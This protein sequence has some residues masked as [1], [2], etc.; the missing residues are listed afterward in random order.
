MSDNADQMSNSEELND[1][2]SFTERLARYYSEFLATDFKKGYLPKR[3]F[4]TRDKKGRRTGITLEKFPSFVRVL[5]RSL[6]KPFDANNTVCVKPKAHQAK[7]PN[8]VLA[9]I[10]AEID[11]IEFDE[12]A[13][14]NER[15][16][17]DFIAAINNKDVDVEIEIQ[18]FVHR[19]ERN[20]G[21]VIGAKLI[22][23][24]EPVF[25]KNASNLLD[26]LVAVDDD[27]TEEIVYPIEESLPSALYQITAYEDPSAL[28]DLITS[29][30][31]PEK[32]RNALKEYFDVFS[33]S[34]L[35]TEIR[36]LH[37]LEQLEENKE[38]YLYLG[39]VR[40]KNHV[41]PIFYIPFRIDF[42]DST[43]KLRLE[44]RILVNKKAVDYISR[45]VQE[46]TGLKTASPI[47]NRIIYLTQDDKILEKI[48]DILST[49]LR[50]FQLDGDLSFG[51]HKA[52][53]KNSEIKV[54]N[55]MNMALFD[56]ADESMLTDYEEL[57]EKLG[58]QRTD[59]LVHINSLVTSFL[60]ENPESVMDEVDDEWDSKNI[61]DRL[62]F[63]TPISL[64]EEQ[65]KILTALNHRKG[66]FVTVE[67]PPGTG[68]SHTISAIAFRAIRQGQSVLI[69]SDKKEALDV[70]QNKINHTLEKVRPSD[71]FVNPILR[72][73]RIGNNIG[74]IISNRTIHVLRDHHRKMKKKLDHRREIYKNFTSKIKEDINEKM[75][76][77][78][79]IHLA[80]VFEHERTVNK[81][82][83]QWKDEFDNFIEIFEANEGE[84]VEQIRSI[85]FLVDLR[86]ECLSLDI[87]LINLAKRL[88]SD[89][90]SLAKAMELVNRVLE[91]ENEVSL[92]AVAPRLDHGHLLTIDEKIQQMKTAKWFFGWIYSRSKLKRIRSSI[93]ALTGYISLKSGGDELIHDIQ[94]L[95]SKA[96]KFYSSI[97]KEF[98]NILDII[99]QALLCQREKPY[100]STLIDRLYNIQKLIDNKTIP[101]LGD[102]E[103]IIEIL[104]DEQSGEADFF[105]S[106][107][108]LRKEHFDLEEKFALPR[109]NFFGRKADIE[110]YNSLELAFE[111]DKRAIEFSEKFA[112]DAKT[113]VKIIAEKRKFP[114]DKFERLKQAF[115]CMICSVRDYAEYI[116][117][118]RELFDI[119]IIDEASQV[120][121]AQ[122]FPA[123][124]R[125]K[126]MIVLGD[127]K[128][129]GNVKS[130]NASK[131]IN[132]AYF[133]KV[134][135][136]LIR[137]R[138]TISEAVESRV[139]KL[140]ITNSIMD[141]M[142][143]QRNY[144]VMLRKHFRG[145]PEMISFSSKNFYGNALQAMKIRGKAIEEVLE[146]V[147]LK[148]NGL[149]DKFRN[150]NEQEAQE[151]LCRVIKQLNMGDFRSIAVIT[152]F[153]E[154]Q[155]L[156]SRI[157]SEHER[158][159]EITKKLK[160][161][162][163]TF[164]SCQGEER[165]IIYY[166][167][168]ATPNKDKLWSI[169]PKT[170]ERQEEDE[171]NS[172][173]KLQ[174][175]NVAFSRGKEKL[176]F[177]CSKPITEF[178]AGREALTHYKDEIRNAKAIPRDDAVGSVAERRVLNWI[179][180][181]TVYSKYKPEIQPQYEIG[182]YLATIDSTYKHPM[183]R[184]DFLVRFAI[185]GRQ[186]DIIIEYD[187]FEYHFQN[188]DKIDSGNWYEY[189]NPSD[190]EREH[191][192]ESY[193]CK[194]IR[195][196]KFN[197]GRNPIQTIDDK[198][199]K[200]L[201]EFCE[202]GDNLIKDRLLDPSRD[203]DGVL[204]GTY[205]FCQKCNET[206]CRTK[207][208]RLGI[209]DG[210]AN[211]CNDCVTSGPIK[212]KRKIKRR[213]EDLRL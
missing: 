31:E 53:L 131:E 163:F 106:F 150:T 111:I 212:K 121:I 9:A 133:T 208:H 39:E 57:L 101:F 45:V 199:T 110:N 137:E 95:A 91:I 181:S 103:T 155:I 173:K 194:M 122:A 43:S 190:V 87:S 77:S 172:S 6:E 80:N 126:K 24:L 132:N 48:N 100:C 67:G 203:S 28:N 161:R 44:S 128:Q 21:I 88:G 83:S 142:E 107:V 52:R 168:V 157:F 109:Y 205:R 60:D 56:K 11:K 51:G 82:K 210:L 59:L 115:P 63:D 13:N 202:T 207:F 3:R 16:T 50:A 58:D 19:L 211:Y 196:N 12:L 186:R 64:A 55:S 1:E 41:F 200:V 152:P 14:K 99:P 158:Y 123:I 94:K 138:G 65:R 113:L 149:I 119:I 124:I 2:Y 189:L 171:L 164:D 130:S 159:V 198:I 143:T 96:K 22:N 38:F 46:Q 170:M 102:E 34:D 70:V 117:L 151:I 179:T 120:S 32:I 68:K 89:A 127:R 10:E 79:Q 90:P 17:T 25:Q 105:E 141:F 192:L 97:K 20:V 156:I 72:L 27:I 7:L 174:R 35:A 166:S 160:F 8:V 153:S 145:Y 162:C 187:G 118:E 18:Q 185:D 23:R 140:N 71:D 108:K 148:H 15:S 167:F 86:K 136:S 26:A 195:L 69:L 98:G 201:L 78:Q 4:Q 49:I 5:N 125:A 183:Y 184:V 47:E 93:E 144:Y 209:T 114:R 178:S 129:F 74:K 206:K 191:I 177:V 213:Q 169:L 33:A 188:W 75:T 42:T 66:R 180:Q 154:Q 176:I 92:F 135:D 104:T 147:E 134:K 193:G 84:F 73:G 139:K 116:P 182:R 165:D 54:T 81:F 40:Y 112:N 30:L 37:T 197:V 29:A 146:F 76:K 61:P 85:N 175:M 204:L 36:E 62:I